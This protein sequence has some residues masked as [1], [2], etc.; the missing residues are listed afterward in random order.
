LRKFL[1]VIGRVIAAIF[2][3]MF[4]ITALLSI[5]LTTL[6]GQM[7]NS[8]L[9]KNALGEQNIYD[10]LPAIVGS[11][12]TTSFMND[13]CAQNQLACRMDGASPELQTCLTTALGTTAYEAIGSGRRSP[14]ST[15][16][17][18]AQS[19]LD[20]YGAG[21]AANP[22]SGTDGSGMPPFM[23]NLTKADWQAILSIL[24]PPEILKSMTEGTLDQMFAYLNGEADSVFVPLDTLKQ[25]LLG[26]SGTALFMQ[27]LESQQPCNEQDL[28]QLISGTSEGGMVFCK[29]PEDMISIVKA[30]L[31]DLLNTVVPQIPDKAF[32]IKSPAPGAPIPGSGPFGADPISTLRTIR[33]VMR[34]SLLIPLVF[35]LLVTLLAVRNIK[36]WMR[37]W[38]IPFFF[39]GT[40]ALVL[41]ISVV[42]AFNATW[43]WFIAPRI[44]TFIP[45]DIPSVGL[46]LLRSIIRSLSGWIIVPGIVLCVLGLGAWIGSSYI[47]VKIKLE[48]PESTP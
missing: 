10:R 5:L 31:P 14:T 18:H 47:K 30:V 38:G 17:Q 19:C 43:T 44:P 40:I 11:A 3:F 28:S 34:L 20:R 41:G 8:S 22:Q 6:N 46:E 39:T 42:P 33:L 27:L 9:Y 21:Q 26:A 35:L 32:I 45:A 25:R 23:Q 36:S 13:P 48:Q 1:T 29:P 37:W 7:Y 4:V 12:I 16:L 15:E 2:A 24:L